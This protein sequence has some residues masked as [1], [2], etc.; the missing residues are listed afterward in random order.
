MAEYVKAGGPQAPDGQ[1]KA[2]LLRVLPEE[3]RELLRWPSTDTCVT[4][5]RFRDT[6][7]NQSAQVLMYRG[8]ARSMN[9]VDAEE[10]TEEQNIMKLTTAEP[11][12]RDQWLAELMAIRSGRPA[13]PRGRT[14]ER[15]APPRRATP[16]AGSERGARRCPNCAEMHASLK[17]PHPPVDRE[18]R[19]CW[20]CKQI[21]HSSANSPKTR[22]HSCL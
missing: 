13:G 14:R 3:I 19:P 17:C 20:N 5:A 18:K 21:G 4:F 2:D 12:E 9:A 22:E 8:G 7:V 16:G 10:P 1:M 15:G 11:D 6:V